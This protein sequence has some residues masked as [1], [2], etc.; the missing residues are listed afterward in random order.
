MHSDGEKQHLPESCGIGAGKH[1]AL[2]II[3]S[4]LV[5]NTLAGFI[6]KTFLTPVSA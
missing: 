5:L 6:K 3:S 4:P 1:I 2:A